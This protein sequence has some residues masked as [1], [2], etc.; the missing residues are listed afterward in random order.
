[1]RQVLVDHARRRGALKRGSGALKVTLAEADGATPGADEALDLLRLDEALSALARLDPGRAR[2]VEMRYFAGM[3][4]PEVA[5]AL[6][7]TEW[8]VKKDWK[9]AR[10]WLARRLKDLR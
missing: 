10:A 9:L 2:V 5:L 6:G 3:T 8:D 1:M 4:V 7:R